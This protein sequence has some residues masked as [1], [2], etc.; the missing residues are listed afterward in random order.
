MFTTRCYI[1]PLLPLPLPLLYWCMPETTEFYHVFLF[2]T[3]EDVLLSRRTSFL[4]PRGNAHVGGPC[5]DRSGRVSAVGTR[6][7]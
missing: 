1:N 6:A 4:L 2:D 3:K 5:R 7:S